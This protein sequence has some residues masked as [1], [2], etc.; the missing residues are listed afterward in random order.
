MQAL[1]LAFDALADRFA[2]GDAILAQPILIVVPSRSL[3]LH[4]LDR[5]VA[6]RGGAAAG[7]RCLTLRGAAREILSQATPLQELGADLL[8]ILVR[9][10]SSREPSLQR[11]LGHLHDS[12]AAV[13]GPIED[14]LDAGFEPA[15][16][17]ALENFGGCAVVI[18]HDRWFLDRIA[19]HILAFEGDSQVVWFEGNYADYEADKKRRLGADADQPHR[20]KYKRLDS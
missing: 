12:F 13:V 10:L 16:E 11:S 17:E 8:P 20:I 14:L 15:L 18:S 9:R 5:I 3:R 7:I 6:H 2:L 1:G 19:T 4:L